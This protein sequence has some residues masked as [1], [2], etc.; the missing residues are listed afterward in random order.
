MIMLRKVFLAFLF[1]YA[2]IGAHAD[3]HKERWVVYYNN[4]LPAE[5][6]MDYDVIAFDSDSHPDL[7]PLKAAHKTLL[8]YID[9][10]EAENFRS[11]YHAIEQKKL[12]LGN[13]P[14]WAG[15]RIV[16]IR[17]PEWDDYVINMLLPPI[18]A[19]GFDGILIDAMDSPL[20]LEEDNPKKYHGMKE[21]ASR[22]IKAIRARY[23]HIKI[24]VN[25]GYAAFPDIAPYINMSM[26]EDIY[27]DWQP[28]QKAPVIIS[29]KEREDYLHLLKTAQ[30]KNPQLKVYTVDYWPPSDKKIIRRIYQIQRD[31]GFVPYVSVLDLQSVYPEP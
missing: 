22:L 7:A 15:H 6:F 8:G 28:D 12:L 21:G 31:A 1:L 26:G 19:Q 13:N 30:G 3:D 5:K 11:Y 27:T 9:L 14:L 17:K 23:P 16:D 4:V 10:G 29:E 2:A 20:E 18:M 25:R 24:M